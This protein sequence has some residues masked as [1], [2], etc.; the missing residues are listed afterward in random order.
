LDIPRAFQD[1]SALIGI[2]GMGYVGLPLMLASTAKRFHVLGFDIDEEKVK[3]L[4][5]GTSP[6]KHVVNDRIA[7]V[8]EAQLFEATHD[9]NRLSEVDVMVICVSTPLGHHREP[10]LSF[11]VKT[12]QELLGTFIV[13]NSSCSI[14]Q[15]LLPMMLSSS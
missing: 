13:V 1:R 2:V 11:V 4:N 8:R 6:L 10:D 3:G 15:P 5:L 14:R 9:A 12:T 7:A